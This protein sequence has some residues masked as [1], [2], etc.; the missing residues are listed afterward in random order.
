MDKHGFVDIDELAEKIQARFNIKK[1]LIQDITEKSER[2]RFEI[3]ENRI[4]A[5]YGHTIPI[6]LEFNEDKVSKVYYHG[7]TPEAAS[8]ILQV[9]LKPMKRNWVHLSP[10]IEIAEEVGSR[11]SRHPVILEINA[12]SARKNGLIFYEATSKVY[13]CQHVAPEYIK[14]AC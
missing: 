8:Q 13:L 4:R 2:Q 6:S 3:I 14:L 12:E 11:R 10:T 5:L 7:T 9:G 1:Q